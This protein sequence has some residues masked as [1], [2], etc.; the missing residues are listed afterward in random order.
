MDIPTGFEIAVCNVNVVDKNG[1]FIWSYLMDPIRRIFSEEKWIH[2]ATVMLTSL[3]WC[4]LQKYSVRVCVCVCVCACVCAR[5]CI[6]PPPPPSCYRISG[7]V[8]VFI[9]HFLS[10]M[11]PV[12]KVMSVLLSLI[13]TMSYDSTEQCLQ[14]K[15][16]S[17]KSETWC[18]KYVIQCR[19]CHSSGSL[20]HAACCGVMGSILGYSV[21]ILWW[22]KWHTVFSLI[23]YGLSV[24]GVILPVLHGQLSWE[25]GAKGSFDSPLFHWWFVLVECSAM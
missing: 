21:W 19:L 25:A 3:G 13:L 16:F 18:L 1:I 17:R 9:T 15:H 22:T 10:C 24:P 6:T 20:L 11:W 8:G 12:F 4:I 14:M 7:C 23:W 2:S 5:A